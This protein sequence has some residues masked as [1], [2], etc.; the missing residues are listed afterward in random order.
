MLKCA[1]C[2]SEE[3]KKI[4]TKIRNI[5]DDK[6]RVYRCLLCQVQFLDPFP[7]EQGLEEYYN[8]DYRKEYTD[9]NYYSEERIVDFFGKSIPEAR[10]RLARVQ[11]YLKNSD[12]ILEIGCSSGYFLSQ[13]DSFVQSASGTEWDLK[14]GAYAKKIGFRVEKILE[15]FKIQFDKIFMFHVLEHIVN[16][17]AF[18]QGLRQHLKKDGLVFIEVPNSND[19]LLSIYGIQEFKDFYYQSAHL[20]Y[21]NEE[22]LQ[23]IL[24]KAGFTAQIEPLQRYDFSNHIHWLKEKLPGGQALYKDAFSARFQKEYVKELK[25]KR[26]TDTIFAICKL[27][28]G[29]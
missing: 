23:Y 15:E 3:V 7:K 16:P 20:W 25:E 8:G 9:N 12:D 4:T 22:S 17:I 13:I 5:R 1:L 28:E 24:V 6:T 19:A 10:E 14:N 21:F 11:A 2:Q 18:L 27:K 29:E 26:K